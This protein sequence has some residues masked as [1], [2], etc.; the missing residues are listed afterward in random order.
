MPNSITVPL[1]ARQKLAI[2]KATGSA[3]N[4]FKVEKTAGRTVIKSASGQSEGPTSQVQ[5][6]VWCPS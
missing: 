1:T 3:I 5:E 2:K 6:R 4:A